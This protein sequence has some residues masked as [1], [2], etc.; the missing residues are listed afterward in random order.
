MHQ[1]RSEEPLPTSPPSATSSAPLP[2]AA[3]TPESPEELDPRARYPS[4]P[5]SQPE[6]Q[7]EAPPSLLHGQASAPQYRGL[8]NPAHP[9][10]L[11]LAD[12]DG[13]L[14]PEFRE[15]EADLPL[16][17]GSLVPQW[18]PWVWEGEE[19]S[20]EDRLNQFRSDLIALLVPPSRP[21]SKESAPNATASLTPPSLTPQDVLSYLY[22]LRSVVLPA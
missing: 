2:P 22:Q 10:L 7:A 17:P 15:W 12:P 6:D 4:P 18:Y 3:P 19:L 9:A 16:E 21:L 8:P 20:P 11:L 13:R 14:K 5:E 1:N